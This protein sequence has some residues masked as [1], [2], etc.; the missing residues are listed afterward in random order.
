MKIAGA[1]YY[2][3]GKRHEN[4]RYYTRHYYLEVGPGKKIRD[5]SGTDPGRIRDGSGTD[6]GRVD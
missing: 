1:Y 6:P 3:R 2:G 4:S 5:G